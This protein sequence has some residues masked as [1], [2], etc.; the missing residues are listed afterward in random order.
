MRKGIALLLKITGFVVL[1]IISLYPSGSSS[2][3]SYPFC[4]SFGIQRVQVKWEAPPFSLKSLDGRQVALSDFRGKPIMLIFWATWCGS[5]TDELPVM[6]KFTVG[7]RDQ[8]TIL[9]AA[10]DGERE[11]KVQRFVKK[12]KI[13]LPV[14]LDLK[15]RLARAYGVTMIPATFFIDRD[16]LIIGMI[17]GERD[18]SSPDAWP[19][20]QEILS[21]R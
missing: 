19:A 13:T 5:C 17:R 3:P 4:S 21:L 7:K 14:L 8:L 20:I 9:T 1:F 11:T 6:D 18:W 15:E 10:I 16:G 12:E 2:A